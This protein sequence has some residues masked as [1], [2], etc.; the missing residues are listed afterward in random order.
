MAAG[1]LDSASSRRTLRE[2]R[3]ATVRGAAMLYGVRAKTIVLTWTIAPGRRP[4]SVSFGLAGAMDGIARLR[5]DLPW[6]I[7]QRTVV[8]GA[9]GARSFYMPLGDDPNIPHLLRRISTPG[10]TDTELRLERRPDRETIDLGAVAPER[11]GALRIFHA[12]FMPESGTLDPGP[13]EMVPLLSAILL[14]ADSVV[15]SL[16]FHRETRPHSEPF[17]SLLHLPVD[18]DVQHS[19]DRAMRVPLEVGMRRARGLGLPRRCAALEEGHREAFRRVTEAQGVKV[20]DFVHYRIDLPFPTPFSV[21]AGQF[22]MVG[23]RATG[24]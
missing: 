3:R 4:H 15:F 9:A 6:A 18:L 5:P 12:E 23:K 7:L 16:A 24:G 22:E 20:E 2:I 17:A 1:G 10:V 8:L 11:N 19:F 21:V 14:P 13:P